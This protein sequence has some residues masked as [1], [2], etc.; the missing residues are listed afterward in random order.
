M[1]KYK[2]AKFL[3]Y[4]TFDSGIG[5]IG[6]LCSAEGLLRTTLPQPS[7]EEAR[8]LLGE[9]VNHAIW[10][11]H[12]F[13]DLIGRFRAYFGGHKVAFPGKLDFT[14]ATP[15]QRKVLEESR[16]I[17]YG[18]TR[19]YSWLAEHIGKPGAVRAVG[20]ALARNPLPIIVPCHR[21]VARDGKLGGF[22]GG[23]EMKRYLLSLESSANI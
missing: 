23:A 14:E 17:P 16:L 13:D 9:S 18:E 22:S 20:Q 10:A 11:P 21:V 19:S 5:W 3:G 7:V 12:L 4:V 15:F 8:Q 1:E 2:K 6:I